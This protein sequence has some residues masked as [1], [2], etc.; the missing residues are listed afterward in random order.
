MFLLLDR[1]SRTWGCSKSRL[2]IPMLNSKLLRKLEVGTGDG[3]IVQRR[4]P[5]GEFFKEYKSPIGAV[6]EPSAQRSLISK[7]FRDL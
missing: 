5:P 6:Q 7:F 4:L 3:Y 1:K 2:F